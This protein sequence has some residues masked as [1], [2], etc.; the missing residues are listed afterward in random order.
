MLTDTHGRDV[1]LPD[2]VRYFYVTTAHL[3][4]N[5]GCRDAANGVS[6]WP[7]YR[8]AYDDLVRWVRDGV[9]PPPT[10]APSVARGTFVTPDEQSKQYPRIPGKPYNTTISEVGVRDFSVFP[11]KEGAVKYPLYVARLDRD[12]NPAA[13]IIVPEIA[14]PVATLSGKAVRGKGF[15]EGDLCSVNGSSLPLPKTKAE[16]L[17]SG[18]PRLSLEERYPGG[19]HER[20]EKYRRAVEKL[21]ADRYL[22]AEDG[23]KLIAAASRE[24]SQ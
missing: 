1:M 5:A 4:G 18:D 15:A 3:Q 12:G 2:D 8:A 11:P 10:S 13:G 24:T 20:A 19:E 16:R 17:A 22:L 23:A 6:P 9:M 7:Y 21:V 14:A